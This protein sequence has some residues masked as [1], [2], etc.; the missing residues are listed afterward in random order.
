MRSCLLLL[1]VL[2]LAGCS[3]GSKQHGLSPLAYALR[4]DAL[5]ARYNALTAR[6]HGH[7]SSVQKLAQIAEETRVLLDR[8]VARLRALPLPR[9]EEARARQWLAS[10]DRLRHDVVAIRDAAQDNDLAAVRSLALTA[11]RDDSRSNALARRLGMQ[12]CG[13]G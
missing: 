4:A 1:C 6:L 2:L 10:L 7:G 8:T 12:A 9:D 5:C 13:S 3:G 11:E